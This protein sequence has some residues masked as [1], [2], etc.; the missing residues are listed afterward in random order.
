[1]FLYC[2]SLVYTPPPTHISLTKVA[3]REQSV[4]INFGKLVVK[5]EKEEEGGGERALLARGMGG[6]IC[7]SC[8]RRRHT[9]ERCNTK[10]YECGKVGHMQNRC[11]I[12]NSSSSSS[13][14]NSKGKEKKE[15]NL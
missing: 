5:K 3:L 2:S 11:P 10:C 7:E 12:R 8:G 13:N 15:L 9:Q 6:I 4:A 14:S 1:M